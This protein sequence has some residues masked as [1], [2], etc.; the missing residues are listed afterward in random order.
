MS[1]VAESISVLKARREQ[2]GLTQADIA[3]IMQVRKIDVKIF[4]KSTDVRMST[5]QQYARAVGGK[6]TFSIAGG[7]E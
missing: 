3:R 2:L 6:V 4:E 5:L 7:A 1:G